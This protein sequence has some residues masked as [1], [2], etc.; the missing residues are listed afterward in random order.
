MSRE[1]SDETRNVSFDD[2]DPIDP[3]EV[4]PTCSINVSIEV[5]KEMS[6]VDTKESNES[7]V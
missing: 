5:E 6:S 2:H 7:D 4:V 1:K 3:D